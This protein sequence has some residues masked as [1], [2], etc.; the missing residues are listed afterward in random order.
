[1]QDAGERH[2][3]LVAALRRAVF[4]SPAETAPGT[5]AAAGSGAPV[6]DPWAAY[7]AKVRDSSYRITDADVAALTAAGCSE[8]QIFEIT[9]AAATGA[10][11][12]RLDAGLRA[13]REAP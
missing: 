6:P 5:R 4:E 3:D 1:M 7:V 12:Q 13:L 9:V 2:A 8:E 10:A 11:L